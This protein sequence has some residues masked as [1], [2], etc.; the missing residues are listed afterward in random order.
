M[1]KLLLFLCILISGLNLRAQINISVSN[2]EADSVI[3]GNYDPMLYQPSVIINHPDSILMGVIDDISKDTLI[4]WLAKIDTYQNRNT[5]SD[6]VSD[7]RGIGAVRRWIF[8]KFE[9]FSAANENR[10]PHTGDHVKKYP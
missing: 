10:L 1:N 9:E 2:A 7:T 8:S 5:G 4:S 6:T 3:M